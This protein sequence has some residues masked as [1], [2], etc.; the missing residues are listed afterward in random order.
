VAQLSFSFP[1]NEN[2]L[3]EDFIILPENSAAKNLLEKF[4]AQ[5]DFSASQL[6]S[7]ILK[8]EEACGK[9]HLLHIYARKK[10]AQFIDC[11]KNPAD[12]F[13]K[14][15]FYILDDAD[16]IK[17]DELLLHIVN[18]ASEAKAFLLLSVQNISHFKLRDLVSRLKNIAVAE[19]KNP[20]LESIEQ[21]LANGFA[22]SQRKVSLAEIRSIS[23]KISRNYRAISEVI[24]AA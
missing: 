12:F 3:E 4:F 15:N 21:L 20:S 18:S 11:E 13:S 16:K 8:G 6:T 9:T 22:R 17:D 1:Q 23:K 2:Y 5:K 24:N 10:S 19:I 14:N 7:L